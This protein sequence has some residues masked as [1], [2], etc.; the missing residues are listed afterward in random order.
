MTSE[1]GSA[2]P[3][4]LARKGRYALYVLGGFFAALGIVLELVPFFASWVPVRV[5]KGTVLVGAIILSVGRFGSD[6]LV[7]RFGRPDAPPR[8]R[9]AD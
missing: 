1:S 5:A 2:T 3:E 9:A 6:T 7:R 8:A 4:R